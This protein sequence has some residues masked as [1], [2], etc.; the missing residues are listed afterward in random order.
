MFCSDENVLS[1]LS[2]RYLLASQAFE[3]WLVVT[4]GKLNFLKYRINLNLNNNNLK[5]HWTVQLQKD[6]FGYYVSTQ[7][8]FFSQLS[9][10][11]IIPFVT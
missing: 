6:D 7:L 1:P 4:E 2:N 9:R 10:L 11:K 3:T 8:I 5:L